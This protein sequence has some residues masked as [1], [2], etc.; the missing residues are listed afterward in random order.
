MIVRKCFTAKCMDMLPML[1]PED[2]PEPGGRA[3][4][5]CRPERMKRRGAGSGATLTPRAAPCC[6]TSG[7]KEGEDRSATPGPAPGRRRKE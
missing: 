2:P 5:A 4:L 6:K 3:R 7:T 1:K